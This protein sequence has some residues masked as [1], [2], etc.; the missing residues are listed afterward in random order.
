MESNEP[1]LSEQEKGAP[2]ILI[3]RTQG[4]Q[5]ADTEVCRAAGWRPVWFSP[6]KIEPQAAALADLP[7]QYAQADAV[8]WV[9]P[10][11]VQTGMTALSAEECRN[12]PNIAVGRATA[13]ALREAGCRQV[14]APADGQDSEAVLRLP[15]WQQPIAGRLLIVSGEGGRNLL[16]AVLAERGWQVVRAAVYRREPQALDWAA[17]RAAQPLAAWVT[18]AELVRLLFGQAPPELAQSLKSLLYL[19]HHPKIAEALYQA[20]ATQVEVVERLD[21]HFLKSL[22]GAQNR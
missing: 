15:F 8:F 10:S 19:V 11:A 12:K 20:G 17:Y 7:A 14:I 21:E 2:V 6:Q 18:S 22:H 4:R 5:T 9:S 1:C 13:Q 16:A 3:V